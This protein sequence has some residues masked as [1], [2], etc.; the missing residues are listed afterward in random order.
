M[1][2]KMKIYRGII[3]IEGW[4]GGYFKPRGKKGKR[5]I[6]KKLRKMNGQFRKGIIHSIGI[7]WEWS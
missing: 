4:L 3:K 5:Y 6:H 1:K 7:G 2:E